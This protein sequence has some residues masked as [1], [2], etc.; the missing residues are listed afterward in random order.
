[1]N[2]KYL[3]AADPFFKKLLKNPEVRMHYEEERAKS[4]IAMAVHA[5]RI[6]AKLTQVA[7][8]KKANTTQGVIARLESGKDTRVPSIPLLASV[9]RACGG[10][11]E[12]GFKFRKIA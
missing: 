11:F 3:K 2:K 9:G 5:A 1:M 7:L 6:R 8:A 4:Q 12:F 10:I